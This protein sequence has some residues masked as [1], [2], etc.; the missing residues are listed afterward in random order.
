MPQTQGNAATFEIAGSAEPGDF[1]LQSVN[2]ANTV[3]P[4][5]GTVWVADPGTSNYKPAGAGDEGSFG[6][7][8]SHA[9][10]EQAATLTQLYIKGRVYCI[11]G[12]ALKPGQ[13]VD[14]GANGKV[15]G[16]DGTLGRFLHLPGDDGMQSRKKDAA[17]D[18]LVLVLL[19]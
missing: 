10:K 2:K 9:N 11:A 1:L 12:G 7:V 15:V 6:I 5:A 3:I 19:K 4:I 18:D 14:P 17:T 8:A 13:P 16:G